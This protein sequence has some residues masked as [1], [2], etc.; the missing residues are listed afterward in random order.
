MR[1]QINNSDAG[2]VYLDLLDRNLPAPDDGESSIS[3]SKLLVLGVFIGCLA[4]AAFLLPLLLA[5]T[6]RSASRTKE[7]PRQADV[8]QDASEVLPSADNQPQPQIKNRL[9]KPRT[10]RSRNAPKAGQSQFKNA[11]VVTAPGKTPRM[12]ETQ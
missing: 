1:T 5:G 8:I 4:A 11:T 6:S 10:D 2:Q 3:P 7:P 12:T 9:N